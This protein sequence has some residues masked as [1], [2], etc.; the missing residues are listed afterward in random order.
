[1]SPFGYSFFNCT[2]WNFF[3]IAISI[4]ITPSNW[5]SWYLDSCTYETVI[6]YSISLVD[7]IQD[8]Y[9]DV[10][11]NMREVADIVMSKLKEISTISWTNDNGYTV[12]CEYDFN[13]WWTDTQESLRVFTV[14]CRFTVVSK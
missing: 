12:K 7:R 8:W 6:N 4:I 13:W 5:T 11:D 9:A 2:I 14:D 1:M 10:E 3:F